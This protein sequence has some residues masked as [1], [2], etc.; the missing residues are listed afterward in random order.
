MIGTNKM[1]INGLIAY[2]VPYFASLPISR[3]IYLGK[4]ASI[5]L[6]IYL[7]P[8]NIKQKTT[9]LQKLLLEKLYF[10]YFLIVM[11]SSLTFVAQFY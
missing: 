9:N 11:H 4:V 3:I 6:K 5:C 10:I 7:T 2:I 1:T 8:H